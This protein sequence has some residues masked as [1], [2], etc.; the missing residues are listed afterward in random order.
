[1]H[2]V[3]ISHGTIETKEGI[4]S[5]LLTAVLIDNSDSGI[6]RSASANE[7]LQTVANCEDSD[8][9]EEQDVSQSVVITDDNAGSCST[10]RSDCCRLESSAFLSLLH[11]L[12]QAH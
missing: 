2:E 8:C 6:K 5:Q 10:G 7:A 1:L 9:C 12:Q 3:A 4:T 11:A